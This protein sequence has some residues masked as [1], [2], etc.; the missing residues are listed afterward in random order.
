MKNIQRPVLFLD[1]DDVLCLHHAGFAGSRLSQPV[2]A[3][4]DRSSRSNNQHL[5]LAV[6]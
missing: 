2:P 3:S 6:A 5:G 4:P 1:F